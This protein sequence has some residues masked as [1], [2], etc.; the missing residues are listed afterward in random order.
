MSLST[1]V[2]G[3]VSSEQLLKLRARPENRVCFDCPAKNPRWASA[4]Y[5]VFICLDCSGRHRSLGTHISYVRSAE[6]DTWRPEHLAAMFLGGNKRALDFF[7]QHGWQTSGPQDVEVK[8]QSSAAKRYTKELYKQVEETDLETLYISTK[9]PPVKK[10]SASQLGGEKG[11]DELIRESTPPPPPP[12]PAPAPANAINANAQPNSARS[13]TPPPMRAGTPPTGVATP[14][15]SPSRGAAAIER[16]AAP[17]IVNAALA[18]DDDKSAQPNEQLDQDELQEHDTTAL[19]PKDMAGLMLGGDGTGAEAADPAA[20]A[21]KAAALTKRRAVPAKRATG[22]GATRKAPAGAQP[23]IDFANVAAAAP[24]NNAEKLATH[25][26]QQPEPSR[27]AKNS[28]LAAE[29]PTGTAAFTSNT[30]TPLATSAGAFS[31]TGGGRDAS[32]YK[33]AASV[34]DQLNKFKNSKGISSDAFFREA[35]ETEDE[36]R[37]RE[38]MKERFAGAQGISSDMYFDKGDNTA[39]ASRL[40]GF[41]NGSADLQNAADFIMD[42]GS[43][44]KADIAAAASRYTR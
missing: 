20:L 17:Q 2:D 27:Y 11:L 39:D 21:R 13:L 15:A 22:L 42:L 14:V 29:A 8:Y 31:I 16:R 37:E 43:K 32:T 25:A 34:S 30:S 7:K 6:M 12:V 44:V 19:A 5:G 41:S 28:T 40:R 33:N 38:R 4:T 36:K 23:A 18:Q 35:N 24:T 9:S 1:Y 3:K 26:A 10:L